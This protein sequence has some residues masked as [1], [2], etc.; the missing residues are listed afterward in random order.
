MAVIED[1]DFLR[2]CA[3]LANCRSISLAAARRQVELSAAKQAVRDIE[4]KK[5]I[6]KTLLAEAKNNIINNDAS[7]KQLDDLLVALAED[8]NF[9]VED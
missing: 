8:E 6:A 2:I 4:S 5:T 1:K 7:S 3:E 9:M